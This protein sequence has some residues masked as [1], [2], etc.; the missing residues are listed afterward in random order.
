MEAILKTIAFIT[1][2]Y[3]MILSSIALILGGLGVVVEGL[4]RIFPTKEE[5]SA[6]TK[7]GKFL[8]KAG[9]YVKK[10][11]DVLRLPNVKKKEKEDK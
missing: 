5:E 3:D 7:V 9:E 4:T 11:L 10:L 8:T 2:N 6:L 1:T